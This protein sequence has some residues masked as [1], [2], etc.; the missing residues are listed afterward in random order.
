MITLDHGRDLASVCRRVSYS[1]PFGLCVGPL[2]VICPQ[3]ILGIVAAGTATLAFVASRQLSADLGSSFGDILHS[4]GRTASGGYTDEH[5]NE[6][7][8]S[9]KPKVHE[10]DHSTKKGAK[11]A[12]RQEGKGSPV[13]HPSPTKGSP[14]FHPT[15]A[16]GEKVPA[17]THH[18]YPD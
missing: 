10:V 14:H 7:G 8:P 12:A 11:D 2:I 13:Q 18:N 5:G 6:L 3:I 1:D 16:D 4:E 15:D 17:S 9:G